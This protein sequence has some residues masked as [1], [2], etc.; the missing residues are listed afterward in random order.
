MI[1][2]DEAKEKCLAFLKEQNEGV[3]ATATTSGKPFASCIYYAVDDEFNIY[4]LTSRATNKFKNI[5]LN[6]EVA[7]V[8][9]TGPEYLTVQVQGMCDIVPDEEFEKATSLLLEVESRH[10]MMHWPIHAIKSLDEKGLVLLKVNPSFVA[11]LTINSKA[12]PESNANYFYQI[13]P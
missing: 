9:G 8:V 2:K 3:L 5:L 13:I 4:F 7:F 1:T 10:P 11:F 12:Y 6:K